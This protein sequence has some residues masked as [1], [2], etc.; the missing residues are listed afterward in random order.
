M[1]FREY[2]TIVR[3]TDTAPLLKRKRPRKVY[4][5]SVRKAHGNS[6]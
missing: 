4:D 2:L 3:N 6:G 1:P 5:Y